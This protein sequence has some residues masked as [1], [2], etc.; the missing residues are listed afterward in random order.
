MIIS[1][2]HNACIWQTQ[3]DRET[4]EQTDRRATALYQLDAHKTLIMT[5]MQPGLRAL[6]KTD[7]S[8]MAVFH[9]SEHKKRKKDS[10]LH[11]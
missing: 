8:Y 3:I 6:K 11:T 9:S 1:F 5:V 2:C 10:V 7:S 4:D